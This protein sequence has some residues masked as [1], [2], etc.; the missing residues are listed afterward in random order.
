MNPIEEL[1]L[2]F[3]ALVAQVPEP[4]QPFV[5]M[6]AGMGPF[7]EGDAGGPIGVIGG[8]NPIVAAIAAGAGNLLAVLAVVT[9][10]A[11]TRDAVVSRHRAAH[12]GSVATL[13][14]DPPKP[15]SKGKRRVQRWLVRFGVPGASLLAPLAI[16]THITA[17]MLVASGTPR[18]WVLL[19]QAIAIA[20]WTTITTALVWLA[21]TALVG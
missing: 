1:V 2:A 6:L 14:A 13:E 17:A 21:L 10:S 19:W 3:Q 8:L 5:V 12:D 15:A 4:V 11:R 9:L 18:G 7:I 20:V 16:P